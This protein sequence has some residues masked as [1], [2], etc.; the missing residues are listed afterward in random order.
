MMRKGGR[1]KDE[2]GVRKGGRIKTKLVFII[3]QLFLI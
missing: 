2:G 3:N 1:Q